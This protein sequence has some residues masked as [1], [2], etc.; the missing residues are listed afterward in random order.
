[1]DQ[2]KQ[3]GIWWVAVANIIRHEVDRAN[4]L[5]TIGSDDMVHRAIFATA[6]EIA[7]KIAS[8]FERDTAR[9]DR[10]R[11]FEACGLVN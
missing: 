10:G 4:H 3:N 2:W 9:F 5:A 6:H 8:E 11:F 7:S 1:M